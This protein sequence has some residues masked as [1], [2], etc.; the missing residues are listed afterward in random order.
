MPTLHWIGKEKVVNLWMHSEVGHT[1]GAKKELKRIFEG[2]CP[3]DTPKPSSLIERI[4]QIATDDDSIVLDSF[5]GSGTTGHAV[6]K[7]NQ[8]DNGNTSW[9]SKQ[10]KLR[11]L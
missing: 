5:A 3:F 7:Q 9:C 6:L 4:L 1:D 2:Q 11:V 10:K 8:V